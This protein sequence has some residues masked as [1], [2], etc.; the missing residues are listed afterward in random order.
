MGKVA[1]KIPAALSTDSATAEP[2]VSRS[3]PRWR[4]SSPP[5]SSTPG[6]CSRSSSRCSTTTTSAARR[7]RPRA[8]CRTSAGSTRRLVAR[9]I[10]ADAGARRRRGHDHRAAGARHCTGTACSG[11]AS[12]TSRSRPRTPAANRIDRVLEPDLQREARQP[13]RE[14]ETDV[15]SRSRSA[16][17]GGKTVTQTEDHRPDGGRQRGDRHVPRRAGA[18]DRDRGRRS[19]SRCRKVA[20]RDQHLEQH[21][22]ST[23]LRAS[24]GTRAS[25]AISRLPCAAMGPSSAPPSGSSR[26]WRPRSRCR[27]LP[28]RRPVSPAAPPARRPAR[29]A[30]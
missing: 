1:D 2:A 4:P 21:A 13:G 19:R 7:S 27:R 16:R 3:P 23:D 26:W 22:S 10:H 12:A 25:H 17:G 14:P 6:A 11:S 30:R 29:G 24:A 15:A 18:A 9:R 8:S 20:R 5:T 28:G